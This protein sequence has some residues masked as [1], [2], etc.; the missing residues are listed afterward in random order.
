MS[1]TLLSHVDLTKEINLFLADGNKFVVSRP[2]D[3]K[4]KDFMGYVKK[5]RP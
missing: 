2:D 1:H 5:N 3:E 4:L